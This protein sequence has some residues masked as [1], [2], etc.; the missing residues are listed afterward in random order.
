M[1]Y[2][3]DLDDTYAAV[4]SRSPPTSDPHFDF[5]TAFC[6]FIFVWKPIPNYTSPKLK[7]LVVSI[8]IIPGLG[9]L[10]EIVYS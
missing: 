8:S 9:N 10:E 1:F 6:S 5:L 2:S 7:R 3:I 4:A